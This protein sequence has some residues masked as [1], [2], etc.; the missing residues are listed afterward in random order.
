MRVLYA[1]HTADL[2]GS[3]VSLYQLM[4][5]L[6]SS[7]FQPVAVFSKDGP[8]VGKL[9]EDDM[10]AFVLKSRGFLGLS[11]LWDAYG[12]IKREQV[13]LVHLNSAVP[14]CKYIGI[15]ARLNHVPVIWHIRE[16]PEGKR[17]KGLKKW[18]DLL[19]DRILVVSSDLEL[20]FNGGGKAVKVY[21]GV[22]TQKFRPGLDGSSFRERF[23]IPADAFVFGAVGTIE[24][25]KGT[26]DFLAAAEEVA[27]G[28]ERVWFVVVGSGEDAFVKA[29]KESAARSGIAGRVIFTGVQANIPEVMNGI[30]ALVMPSLWEGFPRALIETMA[31]GRPAVATDVGEVRYILADGETGLLIQKADR[32]AL[33][34]A[35]RSLLGMAPEALAGMGEKAREKA[36]ANYQIRCHVDT[37]QAQYWEVL[38]SHPKE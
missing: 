9:A 24:P 13:G 37:V 18:I 31:C 30:D 14:F 15:A 27:A 26:V 4:K 34:G 12:L 5:G 23:K 32:T 33:S 35:M 7:D 25:R 36:V 28:N 6:D 2:K 22:D 16:D 8:M 19:A 17:V 1:S 10:P 21:N 3:A 11:L 29:A 38:G 20:F